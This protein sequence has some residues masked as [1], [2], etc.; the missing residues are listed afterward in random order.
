MKKKGEVVRFLDTKK[1]PAK[2]SLERV[3][4]NNRES[5][6]HSFRFKVIMLGDSK[7]GKSSIIRRFCEQTFN[8]TYQQTSNYDFVNKK[9]LVNEQHQVLLQIYDTAGLDRFDSLSGS[10]FQ[11]ASGFVIVFDYSNKQS[12]DSVRKWI[13]ILKLRATVHEPTIVVLGN[14]CDIS[15]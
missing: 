14:K 4:F 1:D 7:V 6:E 9:L 3:L 13:S 8:M 11:G 5:A 10:Y 2:K 12:F 15:K